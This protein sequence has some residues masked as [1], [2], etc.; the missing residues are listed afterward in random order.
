[1]VRSGEQAETYDPTCR[2]CRWMTDPSQI[3]KDNVKGRLLSKR[4][5]FMVILDSYP[6]I[7]GHT[8]VIS[9]KHYKDITAVPDSK[10]RSLGYT[11]S[12]TSKLLKEGLGAE[13]VY[14]MS[15]CEQWEP[16]EI[17]PDW[18]EG[19]EP[20]LHTEHLH[21]HLL[22]RYKKMRTKETAQESVFTRPPDYRCTPKMLESVRREIKRRK[23]HD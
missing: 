2:F 21:F 14:L 23:K 16:K 18:K 10:A 8:L 1:M 6:K 20:P 13:K 9:K 17:K 3:E 11:L 15:M 5:H 4:G 22:P 12:K 7:T 19:D